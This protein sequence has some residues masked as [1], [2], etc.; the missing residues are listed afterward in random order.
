MRY[1]RLLIKMLYVLRGISMSCLKTYD[2]SCIS[3]FSKKLLLFLFYINILVFL[4]V[5]TLNIYR[6]VSIFIILFYIIIIVF[7]GRIKLRIMQNLLYILLIM[8][9]LMFTILINNGG[10]G[11][12]INFIYGFMIVL[13]FSKYRYTYKDYKIISLMLI[14]L[15]LFWVLNSNGYYSKIV[16]GGEH[17]INPNVVGYLILYSCMLICAISEKLNLRYKKLYVITILFIS[18]YG[19]IMLNSRGS[20]AALFFFTFLNYVIPKRYIWEKTKYIKLCYVTIVISGIIFPIVY[21]LMYS[22]DINFSIPFI[23]KSFYTGREIIWQSF[24]LTMSNPI[25]WLFGLGSNAQLI[26]IEGQLDLHNNYLAILSNFGILGF[27]AYY[28]LI[29]KMIKEICKKKQLSHFT[30]SMIIGFFGV[31]I[32]GFFEATVYF[33][34]IFVLMFI[35]LGLA[36]SEEYYSGCEDTYVYKN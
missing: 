28:G 26:Y 6:R 32:N 30:I 4:N 10:I 29:Y 19:I 16:Y 11:S 12:I 35:F 24:F 36:L 25:K 15:N 1:C 5:N 13:A 33:S 31:L 23:N 2:N 34:P 14:I 17:N 7:N 3:P 9:Y 8:I 22:Q 20:F 27:I 21:L 18:Y